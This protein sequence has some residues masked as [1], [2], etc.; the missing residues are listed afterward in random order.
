MVLGNTLPLAYSGAFPTGEYALVLIDYYSR[1]AEV[2]ITT[3]TSA[4]I[5]KWLDFVCNSSQNISPLQNSETPS[6]HGE[7]SPVR[8]VIEY[9]PQAN[10]LV[11][12]F[13]KILLEFIHTSLAE[14]RNWM[15][16]KPIVYL[17]MTQDL[18]Q[19]LCY[20]SQQIHH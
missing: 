3:T 12:R 2:E 9:C 1:W 13:N 18:Y 10:E 16:I 7:S 19:H 8:T 6:K 11:E 5:R 20:H 14:G 4:R 15:V 17:K